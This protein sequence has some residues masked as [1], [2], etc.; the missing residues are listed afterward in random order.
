MGNKTNPVGST[1]AND[2]LGNYHSNISLAKVK[3]N[4]VPPEFGPFSAA[5]NYTAVPYTKWYS[6]L[7]LPFTLMGV[8]GLGLCIASSILSFRYNEKVDSYFK[9]GITPLTHQDVMDIAE[10]DN[11]AHL[12]RNIAIGSGI[13]GAAFLALGIAA[14]VKGTGYTTSVTHTRTEIR[15]TPALAQNY[16]GANLMVT[17]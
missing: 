16:Q 9:P 15:V 3:S 4:G 7:G 6:P 8:T 13:G 1:D 12:W 10:A 11:N 14:L 5:T 2:L 17:F